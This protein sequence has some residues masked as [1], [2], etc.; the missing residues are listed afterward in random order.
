MDGQPAQGGSGGIAPRPESEMEV[1]AVPLGSGAERDAVIRATGE[2]QPFPANV[3]YRCARRHI[4]S[5]GRYF[6]LEP[7]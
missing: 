2:Q 5:E 1:V 3:L 6:R 7:C 4:L